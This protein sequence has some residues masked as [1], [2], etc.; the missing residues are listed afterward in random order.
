[1]QM[2]NV[3]RVISRRCEM[4]NLLYSINRYH[5]SVNHVI[6]ERYDEETLCAG[7]TDRFN[8]NCGSTDIAAWS[9]QN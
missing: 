7:I 6:K 9:H 1:M 8:T 2:W 3:A 5:P 4:E